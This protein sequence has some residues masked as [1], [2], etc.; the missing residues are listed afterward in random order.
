M[1][2]YGLSDGLKDGFI[3]QK[4][5]DGLACLGYGCIEVIVGDAHVALSGKGYFVFGLSHALINGFGVVGAACFETPAQG[6]YVR[7][8]DEY[9]ESKVAEM[10]LDIE[11]A[12]YVYVKYDVIAGVYGVFD[13]RSQG[14]VV[15]SGIYFFPFDKSVFGYG[16]TEFVGGHKMIMHA[17]DF[18]VTR[19]AVG[20]ADTEAHVYVARIKY[21]VDNCG[22]AAA[23]GSA[24]DNNLALFHN[25]WYGGLHYI[26][27]LLLDLFEEVFHHHD[28]ALHFGMIGLGSESVDFASHFL[29]D[30]SEFLPCPGSCSMVSKK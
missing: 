27:Y 13:F 30:K 5:N 11:G 3:F 4:R 18:A 14:A 7:R 10:A 1:F 8:Q 16:V 25:W 26:E 17:I 20:G 2:I 29:G 15:S 21:G 28:Y 12:F 24:D 19:R 23:A 9:G 6:I 22:L